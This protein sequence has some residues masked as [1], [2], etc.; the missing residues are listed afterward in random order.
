MG[1]RRAQWTAIL[2][3]HAAE[4]A[5]RFIETAIQADPTPDHGYVTWIL[6]QFRDE[7]IRLPEDAP[8]IRRLLT[9]WLRVKAAGFSG[10]RDISRYSFYTLRRTVENAARKQSLRQAQKRAKQEGTETVYDDGTC[11]IV[12]LTTVPAAVA[13]ARG[14]NWCT[15]QSD[16][17]A[18]YLEAGPFFLILR[19]GRRYAQLHFQT[20][21]MKDEADHVIVPDGA[22]EQILRKLFQPATLADWVGL[23]CVLG[24]SLLTKSQ[25]QELLRWWSDEVDVEEGG[26]VLV[27]SAT[28]YLET[29]YARAPKRRGRL[30]KL[31]REAL[32]EGRLEVAWKLD[33]FNLLPMAEL[34]RSLRV[35]IQRYYAKREF[36]RLQGL[37]CHFQNTDLLETNPDYFDDA[38]LDTLWKL[39]RLEP[40]A[41][42][43]IAS[44]SLSARRG[45]HDTFGN[46]FIGFYR[47]LKCCRSIRRMQRQRGGGGHD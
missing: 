12:K 13:L 31:A 33:A 38:F 34:Q 3:A 4:E 6:G 37:L 16:Q 30:A 36:I 11:R 35:A 26:D 41:S 42:L 22:L 18:L 43:A 27:E 25:E 45:R 1:A 40:A 29:F 20:G 8:A 9:H 39:F 10:E 47:Q 44:A 17:A 32:A 21:E 7:I 19:N 15:C 46:K 2:K 24:R 23:A 28:H 5:A 14:T